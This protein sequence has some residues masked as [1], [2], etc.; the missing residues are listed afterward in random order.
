MR[1]RLEVTIT[2]ICDSCFD[3]VDVVHNLCERCGK[4]LCLYCSQDLENED[5]T[6]D[7]VCP[8]CKDKGE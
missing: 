7:V 6:F 2:I 3:E 5:G 1:R 8:Q 4:D